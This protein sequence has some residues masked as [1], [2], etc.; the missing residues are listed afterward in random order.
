VR[1]FD[2]SFEN[3]IDGLLASCAFPLLFEP[4]AIEGKQ[5]VDGGVICNV[6]IKKVIEEG[7]DEVF[8]FL[9]NPFIGPLGCSRR[10]IASGTF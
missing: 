10:S 9:T 3:I 2:N 7:C 6:P 4:I 5:Y 1:Y 8:L